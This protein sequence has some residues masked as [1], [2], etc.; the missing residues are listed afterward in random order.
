MAIARLT[1]KKQCDSSVA[2]KQFKTADESISALK[3]LQGTSN[4]NVSKAEPNIT[5]IEATVLGLACN[6]GTTGDNIEVA[7]YGEVSDP[8]FNFG[9]NEMLFLG[10]DGTITAT[11]PTTGVLTRIGY[12]LG[13]GR[14][15]LNIEDPICL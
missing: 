10:P 11:P 1:K 13:P 4:T 15:F 5:F 12:G 8:S 3:L 2:I 9:V 7:T 6:A 14:I